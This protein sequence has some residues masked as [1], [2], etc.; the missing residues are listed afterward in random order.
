MIPKYSVRL[1]VQILLVSFVLS[2]LVIPE[3][4]NNN[5]ESIVE[6]ISP[7]A[8]IEALEEASLNLRKKEHKKHKHEEHVESNSEVRENHFNETMNATTVA[9]NVELETES[10]RKK[11]HTHVH[12]EVREKHLNESESSL[13]TTV[14]N[15]TLVE[16]P[17]ESLNKSHEEKKE[18]KEKKEKQHHKTED[19]ETIKSTSNTTTNN[20]T[21]IITSATNST[22]KTAS[23]TQTEKISLKELVLIEDQSTELTNTLLQTPTTELKESNQTTITSSAQSTC[24]DTCV[25]K[26]KSTYSSLS[27]IKSCAIKACLCEESTLSINESSSESSSTIFAFLIDTLIVLSLFSLII[28][29][30]VIGTMVVKSQSSPSKYGSEP[31]NIALDFSREMEEKAD[32]RLFESNYE[33][34]T[35]EDIEDKEICIR[36][37]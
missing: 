21:E 9:E 33:L 3:I 29:L 26:C 28:S 36:D 6:K 7:G 11:K 20:S 18:K 32:Q 35:T 22:E 4:N 30:I 25:E 5:I 34:M 16:A 17:L 2:E 10:L 8:K 14:V 15:E 19:H 27:E 13:N 12:E 31:D 37:L 23:P 24:F 1:L